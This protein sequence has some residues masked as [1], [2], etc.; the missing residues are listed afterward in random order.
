MLFLQLLYYIVLAR[1]SLRCNA[2]THRAPGVDLWIFRAL[3]L[4]LLKILVSYR[5]PSRL[6]IFIL[7]FYPWSSYADSCWTIASPLEPDYAKLL[8]LH[9]CSCSHSYDRSRSFQPV[10]R[11]QDKDDVERSPTLIYR[12]GD[13]AISSLS[14]C[15]RTRPLEHAQAAADI[16]A[17][18]LRFS[19]A[20]CMLDMNVLDIGAAFSFHTPKPRHGSSKPSKLLLARSG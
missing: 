8:P 19:K 14:W 13:H 16:H 15:Y 11:H 5:P 1:V 7:P 4:P 6:Y 18:C 20:Q 3:S 12:I 17:V 2:R 9:S 10:L